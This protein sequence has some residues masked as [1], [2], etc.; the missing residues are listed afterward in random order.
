MSH[1]F[2]GITQDQTPLRNIL[3][4]YPFFCK[5][6]ERHKVFEKLTT[7]MGSSDAELSNMSFNAA[8]EYLK[9]DL[10]NNFVYASRRL[11]N[12]IVYSFE[13]GFEAVLSFVSP[14]CKIL[15]IWQSMTSQDRRRSYIEPSSWSEI[16]TGIEGLFL[17][18]TVYNEP[19]LLAKALFLGDIIKKPA[20]VQLED[21]PER[22]YIIDQFK[23]CDPGEPSWASA[24]DKFLKSDR[25]PRFDTV[26]SWAF[27]HL[28]SM[29]NTSVSVWKSAIRFLLLSCKVTK[30]GTDSA[31]TRFIAEMMSRYFSTPMQNGIP[32]VFSE[33]IPE[34]DESC[35]SVILMAIETEREKESTDSGSNGSSSAKRKRLGPFFLQDNVVL[36][37][38][39]VIQSLT[40]DGYA[41]N[42]MFRESYSRAIKYWIEEGKA[43]NSM[44]VLFKTCVV[45][46]VERFV[47]LEGVLLEEYDSE[48]SNQVFSLGIFGL[49]SRLVSSYKPSD[50]EPEQYGTFIVKA[51]TTLVTYAS[52]D[53]KNLI[54]TVAPLVVAAGAIDQQLAVAAL[55]TLMYRVPDS[56]RD[57]VVKTF[58]L[59]GSPSEQSIYLKAALD[60]F[61]G[62]HFEFWLT[63]FS[64]RSMVAFALVHLSSGLNGSAYLSLVGFINM[65]FSPM[66]KEHR[67]GYDDPCISLSP[68]SPAG[69]T[70]SS[71]LSKINFSKL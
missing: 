8:Q 17:T 55:K 10:D 68:I 33:T 9:M 36:I 26:L 64:F 57:Y 29:C 6:V 32:T 28:T 41:K 5:G 14:L 11:L 15:D 1:Y 16:R 13:S 50:K 35:Y 30:D 53:E 61:C 66:V 38:S 23:G 19:L 65:L 52:F 60:E 46:V 18:L 44:S 70:C 48:I 59:S 47:F 21:D 34:M 62:Q 40:P 56:I 12:Q 25:D 37:Y 3:L 31:S 45:T 43:V 42:I 54:S 67:E 58:K 22:P 4:C 63:K 27:N 69:T 49:I 24:V 71:M 51:L 7:F 2:V 20:F 39:K